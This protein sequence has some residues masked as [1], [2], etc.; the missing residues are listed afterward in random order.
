MKPEDSSASGVNQKLSPPPVGSQAQGY[1]YCFLVL[2][3]P[4]LYMFI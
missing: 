3:W 1:H 2:A 4:S